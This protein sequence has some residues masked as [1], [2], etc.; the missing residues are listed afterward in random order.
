MPCPTN[1]TSAS[2][3]SIS[4]CVWLVPEN[5]SSM[6]KS[7]V[8]SP[9]VARSVEFRLVATR[10]SGTG[11]MYVPRSPSGLS[12]ALAN[13]LARNSIVNSSPR[14]PGPRP[15]S[16]SLARN[17]MSALMRSVEMAMGSAACDQTAQLQINT[18][19]VAM[20]ASFIKESSIM[21]ERHGEQ[22]LQRFRRQK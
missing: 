20:R 18:T 17:T 21:F 11:C 13:S 3:C 22:H 16:R 15:S 1:I 10:K 2:N 7:I 14:V 4:F 6:A 19:T 12:P 5:S 9:L 8:V